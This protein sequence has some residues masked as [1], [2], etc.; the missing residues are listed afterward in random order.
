MTAPAP[1]AYTPTVAD[2]ASHIR[3]RTRGKDGDELGTFTD[4]TSPTDAQVRRS[5]DDAMPYVLNS[6]QVTSI[7]LALYDCANK[8]TALKAAEL[9]EVS[10]F[11]EQLTPGGTV[12]R[13]RALYKDL[14]PALLTGDAPVVDTTPP[15]FNFADDDCA[16]E[17][18]FG[19]WPVGEI[20]VRTIDTSQI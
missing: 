1:P 9:I 10:Y 13:L 19:G 7:P 20:V 4:T 16:Y 3:S 11:G 14:I 2:V 17:P 12:D 15:A 5:I 18:S 8:M 6:L